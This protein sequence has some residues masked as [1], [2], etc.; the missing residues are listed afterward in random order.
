MAR[1]V[2]KREKMFSFKNLTT[3]LLSF[4]LQGWLQPIWIRNLQPTRCIGDQ[5]NR[6]GTHRIN[7]PNIKEF[8][9]QNWI[10]GHHI[11]FRNL[12]YNLASC[13]SFAKVKRVFKQS[14]PIEATL[15]DLFGCFAG[16]KVSAVSK[17]V[18]KGQNTSSFLFGNTSPNY[19]VA[20]IFEEV[21]VLPHEIPD[22]RQDRY[23]SC[24]DQ[25]DGV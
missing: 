22:L 5:M 12:S 16:T 8:Y 6:K 10:Q 25:L 4:V 1:G 20:T 23:L 9:F 13:A 24:F 14:G 11:T 21:R 7:A 18:T 19:L 2:P 3:T 15:Q 17:F